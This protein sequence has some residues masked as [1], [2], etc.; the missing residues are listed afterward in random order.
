MCLA[1]ELHCCALDTF[2][3]CGCEDCLEPSCWGTKELEGDDF[4]DEEE[5]LDR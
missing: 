2:D 1:C 5:V 4:D 3:E